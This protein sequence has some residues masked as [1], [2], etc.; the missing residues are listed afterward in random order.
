MKKVIA[1][2]L[3]ALCLVGL[4]S[5]CSDKPSK[6]DIDNYVGEGTITTL[7][8]LISAN[9]YLVNDVFA[10]GVLQ[11]LDNETA[12]YN[13]KVYKAVGPGNIKNYGELKSAVESVYT[14]EASESL[15]G[16]GRYVVINERLY[17]DTEASCDYKAD[18]SGAAES[19]E[20]VSKTETSYTFTVTVKVAGKDVSVEMTAIKDEQGNLRLA[21]M[22]Q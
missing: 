3:C 13:G 18:W 5:A 15:L 22:Y 17:V 7:K 11:T 9:A 12:E 4:F 21:Q 1:L 14:A 10:G 19:F 8:G 20:I 2:L 16:N 6:K